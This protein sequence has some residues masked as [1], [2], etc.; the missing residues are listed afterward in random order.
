MTIPTGTQAPK[1]R[2]LP[3]RAYHVFALTL[4]CIGLSIGLRLAGI[5]LNWLGKALVDGPTLVLVACSSLI[6][7]TYRNRDALD[8][9]AVKAQQ[10]EEIS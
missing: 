7:A 5:P 2:P 4:V 3:A 10:N 1:K 9:L 8:L 6:W